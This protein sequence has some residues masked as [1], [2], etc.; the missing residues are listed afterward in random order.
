MTLLCGLID[1][2]WPGEHREDENLC[3]DIYERVN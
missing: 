2:V 3:Q 1:I